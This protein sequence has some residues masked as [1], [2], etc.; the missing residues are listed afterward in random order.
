MRGENRRLLRVSHQRPGRLADDVAHRHRV[1]DPLASLRLLQEVLL[2]DALAKGGE[3]GDEKASGECSVRGN[4]RK[5]RLQAGARR[6]R[7]LSRL[8]DRAAVVRRGGACKRAVGGDSAPH[9]D[10]QGQRRQQLRRCRACWGRASHRISGQGDAAYAPHTV[11][12]AGGA[13]AAASSSRRAA[14][15]HQRGLGPCLPFSPI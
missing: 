4:T 2:G 12:C 3:G 14:Q 1:A 10:E 9:S 11:C 13:G 6:V 7:R 15:A 5:R 8:Y